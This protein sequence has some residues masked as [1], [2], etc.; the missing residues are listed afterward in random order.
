MEHRL[1]M[2]LKDIDGNKALPS[3][4]RVPAINLLRLLAREKPGAANE[5]S[6]L[7]DIRSPNTWVAMPT[8]YVQ[9]IRPVRAHDDKVKGLEEPEMWREGL[10][11]A[12]SASN[13]VMPAIA[14]YDG[15]PWVASVGQ[16]NPLKFDLVF[17]DRYFM[18]SN[19]LN[20]LNAL[21][22]ADDPDAN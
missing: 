20:L 14:R 22:L 2:Q 13:T 19:E 9:F 8:T 18:A 6:T 4:L 10:G 12:L 3:N 1:Y 21:L 5:F 7:K 16:A 17:D 11:G 15:M